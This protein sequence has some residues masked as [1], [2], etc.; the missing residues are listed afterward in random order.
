MN[1]RFRR[2]VF[3]LLAAVMMSVAVPF[4]GLAATA[5]IAFSDP[6][7]KVGE[8]VSVTMKFTSTSGE[9]LGNTDVML[10][11]D[12][13]FLEYINETDNASG[14]NGA[15]R[16]WSGLSGTTEVVTV[17]KFKAL[18]AGTATITITSWEGYD[19]QG[20]V[21]T[22][23]KEGTSKITSAGLPT[24]STDATLQTLQI[25]P[26]VLT[27]S[28]SPDVRDYTATV[29]LDT[30]KLTV[31]ARANNDKASVAV[32][33]DE[34]LTEGT[35]TVVCTV[36]AEDGTTTGT[37]T[38]VVTKV[39]GG[40][41]TGTGEPEPSAGPEPEILAELDV[42][43]KKVRIIER[44][45]DVAVPEGFKES[46]IAIGDTKVMGWT[47]AADENPRY[48]V[49]YGMNEA[50]EQD[51]YRYDLRDKTIQ[52]YFADQQTLEVTQDQYVDAVNRYNSLVDTYGKM[53]LILIGLGAVAAVLLVLVII[54][55]VT[56]R[57]GGSGYGS[58]YQDREP[59]SRPSRGRRLTK[60]E[61]Y[62]MGQ[63]DDYEE[64]F[65]E[66]QELPV[67]EYQPEVLD[68]H[69]IYEQ[70]SRGYTVETTHERDAVRAARNEAAATAGPLPDRAEEEEDFEI[71]DLDE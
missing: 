60:E 38:I 30:E 26:G 71:F 51:F 3:G 52:R 23:D 1:I 54:L 28:F 24:S 15:I 16:V 56:R 33:G 67:E 20:Q 68:D 10:A 5:R 9:A 62:M 18:Q 46:S 41:N 13:A 25:S 44:P 50:G 31:S 59:D 57:G 66:E 19:N 49:F 37:Y 58:G 22:V 8:E 36:T 47:W 64:E 65:P 29:G 39:A 7:T 2:L 43:A 14:G 63:E 69:R 53:K 42:T 61:Q 17:L 34:G 6:S 32:Q 45:A 27:P 11:Y 70:M 55:L 4:A 48:C 35:N 40:E 12:P 21:L